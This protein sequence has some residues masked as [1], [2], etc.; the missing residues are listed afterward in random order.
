MVDR[1]VDGDAGFLQSFK[2]IAQFASLRVE[3]GEMEQSRHTGSGRGATTTFPSV[4][5]DVVVVIPVG[6]KCRSV[7]ELFCDFEA[8]HAFIK[9]ERTWQF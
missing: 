8:E 4:D 9:R 1:A 3:D 5:A 2:G 7:A 6:Q